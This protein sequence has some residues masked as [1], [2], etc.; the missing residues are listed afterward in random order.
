M[1]KART[2]LIVSLFIFFVA[3]LTAIFNISQAPRAAALPPP[4]TAAEYSG[5]NPYIQFMGR[6]L[7]IMNKNDFDW[8]NVQFKLVA[9]STAGDTM[10]GL[11]K[12]HEVVISLPRLRARSTYTVTAGEQGDD[13]LWQMQTAFSKPYQVT[14]QCDTPRGA[15]A[16]SGRWE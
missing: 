16:W 15:C 12:H 13:R 4:I 1:C 5:M 7:V 2:C 8:T 6:Q 9:E 10:A 3:G 14:I 11:D